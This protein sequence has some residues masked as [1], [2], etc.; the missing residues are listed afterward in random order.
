MPH[1]GD[2]QNEIY[3]A[4]LRGVLPKVPV[5]YATL[6]QR[7]TA[8]MPP[9]VLNYVQGGCGDEWTQDQN[10]AAFHHWGMVPRMM[11]GTTSR[12][13]STEIL[14][15]N[16]HSPLFMSPI[17]VTGICGQDQHGD[18]AAAKASAI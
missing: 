5:D 17:G 9:H 6:V 8:A 13:L 14:G 10:A 2:Y 16:Y 1:F 12:D 3:G 4:G 15:H 7:A 18:I 11:V